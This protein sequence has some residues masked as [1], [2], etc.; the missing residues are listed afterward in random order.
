MQV[1]TLDE[2]LALG[3]QGHGRT[4]PP[5]HLGRP[6][7]TGVGAVRFLGSRDY[8]GDMARGQ[9]IEHR[10]EEHSGLSLFDGLLIVGGGLIVLFVA[11]GVLISSA[12]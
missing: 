12:R 11:F 9:D 6:A 2:R 5:A 8:A 4:V 3:T 10:G 1:V 7:S